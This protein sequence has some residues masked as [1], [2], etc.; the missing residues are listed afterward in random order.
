MGPPCVL[1]LPQLEVTLFYALKY[2]SHLLNFSVFALVLAKYLTEIISFLA[3]NNKNE[4]LAL[5]R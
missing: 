2:Y 1:V 3:L 4:L 5:L